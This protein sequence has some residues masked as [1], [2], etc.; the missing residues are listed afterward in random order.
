[1]VGVEKA[2]ADEDASSPFVIC[3]PELL[4]GGNCNMHA[5]FKVLAG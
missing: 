2:P 3:W 4:I 1:L 5:A